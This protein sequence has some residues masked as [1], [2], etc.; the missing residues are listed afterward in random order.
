MFGLDFVNL[1][2]TFSVIDQWVCWFE[3]CTSNLKASLMC[4][5]TN[6]TIKSMANFHLQVV[7]EMIQFDASRRRKCV[8]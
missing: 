3:F 6:I 5:L 8:L 2:A 1:L 7:L 4:W